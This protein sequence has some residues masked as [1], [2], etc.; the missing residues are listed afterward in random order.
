MIPQ[1]FTFEDKRNRDLVYSLDINHKPI[2]S[3]IICIKTLSKS[4]G[5]NDYLIIELIL[6][7]YIFAVTLGVSIHTRTHTHIFDNFFLFKI[8]KLDHFILA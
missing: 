6:W 7:A 3:F 8:I 5:K 4:F 1:D 2:F